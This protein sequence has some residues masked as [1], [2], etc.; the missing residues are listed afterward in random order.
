MSKKVFLGFTLVE[1]LITLGVI[2]VIAALTIPQLVARQQEQAI[3]SQL[4]KV[5]STLSNAYTLA[6]QENG[7]PEN[8]GLDSSVAPMLAKLKPYL[9]VDKDCI[10]GSKG[11]FP[12]GITYRY[13]SP[14][15]GNWVLADDAGY[16]KLRLADGTLLLAL[17]VDSSTCGISRGN[18]HALQSVCG[19]YMVDVNGYKNP[20]QFGIDSFEF[21]LTKDGIVPLGTSL[22]TTFRFLPSGYC[23]GYGI[24][25]TAWIIYNENMEY[26]HCSDLT[27]GGKTKCN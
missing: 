1:V 5:H 16:P 9:S 19:R 24:S 10:N 14:A 22:E 17:Q 4:K 18:S 3:V 12:E 2:G 21:H 27:W 20:N 7:T 11:C 13:L 25:C 15:N 23:G 8:W 26:L 6:V